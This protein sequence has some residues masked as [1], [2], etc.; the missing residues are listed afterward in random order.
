MLIGTAQ[1]LE[2]LPPIHAFMA[3]SC[4]VIEQE[5]VELTQHGTYLNLSVIV[6]YSNFPIKIFKISNTDDNNLFSG[7]T[8]ASIPTVVNGRVVALNNTYGGSIRYDCDARYRMIGNDS[9]ICNVYGEW[10][11]D[12]PQ[13]KG[14]NNA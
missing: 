3:T 14:T 13:C 7:I 2:T 8:C 11:G 5:P 10:D 4:M 9:L 12:L 6:R 1:G